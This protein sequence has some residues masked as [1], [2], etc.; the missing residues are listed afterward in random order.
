VS[1]GST[2]FIG[3]VGQDELG[4]GLQRDVDRCG[5]RAVFEVVSAATVTTQGQGGGNAVAETA[6]AAPSTGYCAVLVR[7]ALP[8]P[9]A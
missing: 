8:A 2:A 5:V 4:A 1:A 7:H 3:A 6:P 9:G